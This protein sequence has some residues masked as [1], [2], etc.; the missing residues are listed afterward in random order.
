M[1]SASAA[2]LASVEG[3]RPATIQ[4]TEA[5]VNQVEAMR[6][7]LLT[8]AGADE[9]IADASNIIAAIQAL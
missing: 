8:E 7:Q 6:G 4:Q 9:L 1:G 3:D 5:F 2:A